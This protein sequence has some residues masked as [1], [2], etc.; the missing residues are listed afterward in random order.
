MTNCSLAYYQI[1]SGQ[2]SLGLNLAFNPMTNKVTGYFENHSGLDENTGEPR[3]S[4]IFYLTGSYDKNGFNIDTYYPLN[5][6]NDF[7]K[8]EIHIKDT[9]TISIKLKEDHGGCW[10]VQP[11]SD[12]FIDFSLI[13]KEKWIEISYID[14]DKAYFYNDT[15]EASKRKSYVAKGDIV[16]IDQIKDDWIHGQ[17]R[18][19]S[20]A[21]G[22]LKIQSIKK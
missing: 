10:N 9:K 14:V 1:N 20:I 11:F 21:E 18:G 19:R 4:C 13:T 6:E 17:Y 16:Y 8:G 7:I 2:Y 22:W 12:E 3:F 15:N 5:K